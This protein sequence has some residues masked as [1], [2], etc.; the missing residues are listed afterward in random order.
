MSNWRRISLSVPE[1]AVKQLMVVAGNSE[2]EQCGFVLDDGAILHVEN[3]SD[4]PD[5][6][7]LMDVEDQTAIAYEYQDRIKAI[8]H[9]HPSGKPYLSK[10]DEQGIEHL[11]RVGCPWGYV[12]ATT[13]SVR[14]YTY[15]DRSASGVSA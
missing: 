15:I 11:Y 10:T 3:Q 6:S 12:V 9:T 2:E 7:F 4:R 8:W 13:W 14:E 5:R 1:D